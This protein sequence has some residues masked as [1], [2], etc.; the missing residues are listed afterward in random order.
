MS[1]SPFSL[2]HPNKDD[3]LRSGVKS[4]SEVI[5]PCSNGKTVRLVFSSS[6]SLF[7]P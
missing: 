1:L 6:L 5:Y 4:I 3:F 2:S 7:Y